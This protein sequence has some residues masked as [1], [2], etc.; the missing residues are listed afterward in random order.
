MPR[1]SVVIATAKLDS[2]EQQACAAAAIPG[3]SRKG[4]SLYEIIH[5]F[6]VTLYSLHCLSYNAIKSN[7]EIKD[8]A[9]LIVLQTR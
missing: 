9:W 2:F 1:A 4:I 8:V 5:Y 3:V 7:N 6:H